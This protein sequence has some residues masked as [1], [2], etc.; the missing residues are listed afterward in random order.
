[1]SAILILSLILVLPNLVLLLIAHPRDLPSHETFETK[2]LI[3]ILGCPTL[4]NGHP[5]AVLRR[6]LDTALLY[7]EQLPLVHFL[8]SGGAVNNQHIE[9]DTMA[10][11]LKGRG[12]EPSLIS[13]ERS[14]TKT[15]ENIL[16][17]LPLTHGFGEIYVVTDSL[18]ALRSRVYMH[19]LAPA[20]G[21]QCK[22][23]L[24][25]ENWDPFGCWKRLVYEFFAYIKD[26]WTLLRRQGTSD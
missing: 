1:M 23:L 9:A 3:W 4:A 15:I 5:S 2:V 24:T 25:P 8:V 6:R 20:L 14:S 21:Q 26:G 13:L 11:Y 17:G 22:Y 7:A 16:L 10:A 12:I 19:F 18:H